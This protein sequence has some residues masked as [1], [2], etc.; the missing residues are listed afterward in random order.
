MFNCGIAPLTHLVMEAV[1]GATRCKHMLESGFS[2]GRGL[3]PC[4]PGIFHISKD[5][6]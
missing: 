4:Q 2:L 5:A 1:V 6:K 3:A